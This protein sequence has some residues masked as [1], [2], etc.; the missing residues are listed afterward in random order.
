MHVFVTNC[1]EQS[2]PWIA[3][4][5]SASREILLILCNSKV[6]Y[7]SLKSPLLIPYPGHVNSVHAPLPH[8]LGIHFNIVLSSTPGVST[9][10]HS[11]RFPHQNPVCTCLPCVLHALP[12][13]LLMITRIM[14]GEECR[15]LS[16]SF[17]SFLHSAVTSSIL[18]PNI[19]IST[20]FS[21]TLNLRSSLSVSNQV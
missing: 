20:L 13:S 7:R 16:S 5:S 2:P 9:S 4:R 8:V 11:L 10:T 21:N 19:I 6:H 14:F 18:G 15:S 1:L 12:I 17:C 3:N